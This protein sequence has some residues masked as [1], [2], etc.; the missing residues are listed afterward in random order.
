LRTNRIA[1]L[2]LACALASYGA[3]PAFAD[4]PDSPDA[5]SGTHAAAPP[6]AID[7]SG[8]L[9]GCDPYEGEVIGDAAELCSNPFKRVITAPFRGLARL[10]REDGKDEKKD[11]RGADAARRDEARTA[12]AATSSS[13]T[14]D[15]NTAT[16]KPAATSPTATTAATIDPAAPAAPRAANANAT[17]SPSNSAA[18]P[19]DDQITYAPAPAEPSSDAS[20]AP[21]K[22][23]PAQASAARAGEGEQYAPSRVAS[24]VIPSGDAAAAAPF[25]P[26]VV[27]VPNDPVSQGRALIQHG[28]YEEAISEL[29]V[30]AATGLSLVEANNLLGI[31]YDHRGQHELAREFYERALTLAPRDAHVLSNLGYSLYLDD[32]PRDALA[33]LKLAVRLD[34]SSGEIYNNL[35]FVY[36]RLNK[37]DDAFDSFTQA[38]GDLYARVRTASLL[39]AAGRDRDAI[40]HYEAARKLDPSSTDVL[41]RL[42]T[43]YNRTGQRDKAETVE[44]SLDKPKSRASSSTTD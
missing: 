11:S 7:L 25:T 8:P 34:P 12:R 2:A 28:L 9:A 31:A 21:G 30:A 37:F 43:L 36:A 4:V 5:A 32:R 42:I 14:A 26:L 6:P 13:S 22:T 10:F 35:G 39:E 20:S 27:G 18:K 16:A 3:S 40:R 15:S 19:G 29:S 41:R 17:I 33:K 38:G 23:A 24:P 44:R 1:S